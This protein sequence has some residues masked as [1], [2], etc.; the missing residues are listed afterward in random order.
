M[1]LAWRIVENMFSHL[2]ELILSLAKYEL[3]T[4]AVPHLEK[5]QIELFD[6]KSGSAIPAFRVVPQPQLEIIPI[7]NQQKSVVARQFDELMS[8]AHTG[9]YERFLLLQIVYRRLRLR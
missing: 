4:D 2:Q 1:G 5:F 6:F 7:I 9:E 3:E 8:Y